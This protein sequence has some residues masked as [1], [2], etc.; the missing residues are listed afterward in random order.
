M[1]PKYTFLSKYYRVRV[2]IATG[3]KVAG[4]KLRF[5]LRTC[6]RSFEHFEHLKIHS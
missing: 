3:F 1:T 6:S 4:R 5:E 2:T